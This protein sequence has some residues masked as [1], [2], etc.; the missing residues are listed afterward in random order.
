M[1]FHFAC[2]D[3]ADDPKHAR[4]EFSIISTPQWSHLAAALHCITMN[5]GGKEWEERSLFPSMAADQ[6]PVGSDATD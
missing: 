2:S 6:V 1:H 4:L 5:E 3:A